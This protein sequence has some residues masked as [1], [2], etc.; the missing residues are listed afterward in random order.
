MFQVR[1]ET[2]AGWSDWSEEF[3]LSTST[4]TLPQRNV[5]P[6][7]IVT[8]KE[9][10]AITLVLNENSE[11]DTGAPISKYSVYMDGLK[12]DDYI[13]T[14]HGSTPSEGNVITRMKCDTKDAHTQGPWG[15]RRVTTR[16]LTGG[17]FV[18]NVIYPPQ[19]LRL[20]YPSSYKIYCDGNLVALSNATGTE[21]A[22]IDINL[23]SV[24]LVAVLAEKKT[25][26]S[27]P[28]LLLA[29]PELGLGTDEQWKC[30]TT[31]QSGWEQLTFDDS[32]WTSP[33]VL[34]TAAV[35]NSFPNTAKWIW[36]EGS[37]ED[38]FCRRRL[39]HQCGGNSG[40]AVDGQYST[41]WKI[42]PSQSH[43]WYEI[44]V[45]SYI[46]VCEYYLRAAD[47][48]SVATSAPLTWTLYGQTSQTSSFPTSWLQLDD[49]NV[50]SWQNREQT[51]LY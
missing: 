47:D 43:T 16:S 33:A 34:Q 20:L 35:P 18:P 11:L 3:T 30:S 39:N 26:Y 41:F 7:E 42:P 5:A 22:D 6:E 14:S 37:S 45:Y 29:F 15:E 27:M 32:G 51:F 12:T 48:G 46:S 1:V 4:V 36:S 19:M 50:T 44:D 9:P 21:A 10:G 24:S 2:F 28:G 31:F 23:P 8:E 49:A 25:G 17:V 40:C 13:Y 38:L